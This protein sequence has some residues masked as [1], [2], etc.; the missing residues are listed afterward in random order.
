MFNA[1][2]K[3]AIKR[4]SLGAGM[5]HLVLNGMIK[6]RALDYGCGRGDDAVHLKMDMY[7]PH[8]YP[9]RPSGKFDTITCNFVLNTISI[10]AGKDV[11]A[12]I[13]SLLSEGG[14]AYITVRADVRK[15]TNTQRSA[16]LDKEMGL[17][18]VKGA[19]SCRMYTLIK[20]T[21]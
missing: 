12:D 19:G 21:V 18:R 11:L 9:D 7:D 17:T 3:T 15:D 6:G 10:D 14:C 2:W 4:S 8:W 13:A 20:K 5:K 16:H 1:P